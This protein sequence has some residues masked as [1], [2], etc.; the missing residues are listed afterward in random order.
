MKRTKIKIWV[1]VVILVLLTACGKSDLWKY[2]RPVSQEKKERTE[3]ET[4]T[5]ILP[6]EADQ[7]LLDAMELLIAKAKDVSEGQLLVEIKQEADPLSLY[8]NNEEIAALLYDDDVSRLAPILEVVRLPFLYPSFESIL[9]VLSHP[10]G[11]LEEEPMV[12]DLKGEVLAIYY[13][14]SVGLGSRTNLYLDQLGLEGVGAL[15]I[16]ENQ[17]GSE[18]FTYLGV[19]ELEQDVLDRQFSSFD[20]HNLRAIEIPIGYRRLP[21]EL[22][23]FYPT[24][25]RI[26]TFWLL[27]GENTSLSKE[28]RQYLRQAV[29]YTIHNQNQAR[30]ALEEEWLTHLAGGGIE[31]SRENTQV[32]NNLAFRYL[33]GEYQKLGFSQKLWIY[34]QLAMR[35]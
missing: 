23:Y 26:R 31:V 35:S 14:G 22:R 29:A 10:N 15:G 8:D 1:L 3:A 30:L 6:Q 4:V 25:H 7:S 17:P 5:I 9:T 13:G 28:G 21:V 11:P 18:L 33:R 20:A 16:L 12:Q 2:P 24:H 19:E 27:L 32:I 34:L